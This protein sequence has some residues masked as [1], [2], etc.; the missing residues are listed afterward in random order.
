MRNANCLFRCGLKHK[1]IYYFI[2]KHDQKSIVV[3]LMEQM[4]TLDIYLKSYI[5]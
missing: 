1:T 3:I 2:I 4:T 5:I